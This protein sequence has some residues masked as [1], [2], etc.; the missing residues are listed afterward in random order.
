MPSPFAARRHRLGTLMDIGDLAVIATSPQRRIPGPDSADPWPDFHYLTGLDH[1]GC[2]LILEKP[3]TGPLRERLFIPDPADALWNGSL[4]H[5]LPATSAISEISPFQLFEP[6]L[7]SLAFSARRILVFTGGNPFAPESDDPWLASLCARLLPAH[8]IDRLAPLLGRLRAVKSDADLDAIR[9]AATSAASAMRRAAATIKPGIRG[10]DLKAEFLHAIHH[11]GSRGPGCPILTASGP[12]TLTLHWHGDRRPAEQGDLILFDATAEHDRWHADLAR[13]FPASGTFSPLQLT[14]H[15]AVHRTL[16]AA[17]ASLKPGRLLNDCHHD[18]LLFL[19]HELLRCG[20]LPASDV[21]D[22]SL[23]SPAIRRICPHRI[24]HHIGMEVHDPVPDSEPLAPGA[25]LAVEPGILLPSA[26]FG[27]RL[28][29]TIALTPDGP[30]ILTATMPTS[31]PEI[32]A[33]LR[34]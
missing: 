1:P 9:A 28:E 22:P 5:S 2:G 26:G 12:E 19:Q 29:E 25:A 24:F 8:R 32:E 17:I 3:N 14:A 13:S 20:L 7:R 15:D 16:S 18:T 23:I 27:L 33:L 6:A 10:C 31:A 30:E 34:F 21:P 4:P 11:R